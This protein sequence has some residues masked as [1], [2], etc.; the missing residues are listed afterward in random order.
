[1]IELAEKLGVQMGGSD[2][3]NAVPSSKSSSK[4]S[5]RPPSSFPSAVELNQALVYWISQ[6]A[7]RALQLRGGGDDAVPPPPQPRHPLEYAERILDWSIAWA[8]AASDDN[9]LEQVVRLPPPAA[10]KKTSPP[11]SFASSSYSSN[12]QI[13]RVVRSYSWSL[14][15]TKASLEQAGYRKQNQVSLDDKLWGLYRSSVVWNKLRAL[16]DDP[17]FGNFQPDLESYKTLMT[18]W[19]RRINLLSQ[20]TPTTTMALNAE[21]AAAAFGGKTSV[22]ECLD[23]MERILGEISADVV[24]SDQD[25]MLHNILLS[26]YARVPDEYAINGAHDLL[27]RL[28]EDPD[29]TVTL[30]TQ[31]YNSVLA[32]YANRATRGDHE[33]V[34]RAMELW[35]RMKKSRSCC[36]HSD[37]ITMSIL[38]NLLAK[39]GQPERAEEALEYMEMI[40]REDGRREAPSLLHYNSCLTAWAKSK[41]PDAGNRAEALLH[42]MAAT[43]SE[44]R[45]GKEA[46]NAGLVVPDRI[47]YTA[48]IEALL[49]SPTDNAIDRAEAILASCEKAV[50]VASMPDTAT[51]IVFLRGLLFRHR[52]E[53]ESQLKE[54]VSFR[55]ERILRRMHERS[56]TSSLVRKPAAETYCLVLDGWS[57][58]FSSLAPA[59]ALALVKE[60]EEYSIDPD[61]KLYELA[62]KCLCVKP[63]ADPT[64][65]VDCAQRL[66]EQMTLNGIAETTD[67]FNQRIRL[68]ARTGFVEEAERILTSR[69]KSSS[70]TIELELNEASYFAL[71]EGYARLPGGEKDADR[72][73][74][75]YVDSAAKKLGCPPQLHMFSAVMGAWSRSEDPEAMDRVEELFREACLYDKP[76]G[77]LYGT[78]LSAL[79]R[80]NRQDAPQRIEQILALMQQ[81]Y[82]SGTNVNGRPNASN[83]ATT[84]S[85]WAS[86][87][88]E[89][90]AEH[91]EAILDRL[92]QLSKDNRYRHLK[93]TVACYRGALLAWSLSDR[94]AE[95]GDRAV[96]ILDRMEAK[97]AVLPNQSCYRQVIVAIGKSSDNASKA[98]KAYSILQR[99]N[100]AYYEQGNRHAKATS[101]VYVSLLRAIGATKGTNEERSAAFEYARMALAD[102]QQRTASSDGDEEEAV[103]LQFL[104]AAFKLLPLGEDRET[105]VQQALRR[106]PT[107]L[108]RTES[109]RLA[110][111]KVLSKATHKA[112]SGQL[113]AASSG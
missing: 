87:K 10:G 35:T 97:N 67:V 92:V 17:R 96:A 6:P 61:S 56:R 81:E 3:S 24:R 4:H 16:H 48:A 91:A 103:Y 54:S 60:M 80:S 79:R 34:E 69:A 90:S 78:Y 45:D 95:C 109:M 31:H 98:E 57:R 42:R 47:S 43:S 100:K 28:E 8:T 58:S 86:S 94:R 74:R 32:A 25:G 18:L 49:F 15:G 102:F 5:K 64:V 27:K 62:L 26:A 83:F 68:L 107:N 29:G 65:T 2:D 99:M 66:L 59:R 108:L 93:P 82:E 13:C 106:C 12:A 39:S 50:D 9:F 75:E 101:D 71:M 113:S 46:E 55:M 33:C 104:W 53:M 77:Y 110:L 111:S 112:M 89:G 52:R 19:N 41:H 76:N 7:R 20:L 63:D 105:A 14:Q 1:M 37:P 11:S 88:Q 72:L 70:D 23:E 38:M 30:T 51:Y 73:L 22:R 40:A 85:C 84:I 21:R 44:R 36:D